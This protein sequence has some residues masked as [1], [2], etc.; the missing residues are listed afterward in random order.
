MTNSIGKGAS[1]VFIGAGVGVLMGLSVSPVVHI[2][3]TGLLTLIAAVV[4]AL[5]GIEPSDKVEQEAP[6][7]DTAQTAS[8]ESS[9]SSPAPIVSVAPDPKFAFPNIN[10]FPLFLLMVGLVAGALGGVWLRTNDILGSET[11]RRIAK[12]KATGLEE[13]EIA[14]RIFDQ[15]YPSSSPDDKKSDEKILGGAPGDLIEKWTKLG[16]DKKVAANRLFNQVY[17]VAPIPPAPKTTEVKKA[18]EDGHVTSGI[19]GLYT[20]DDDN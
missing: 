17:P 8:G 18:E 4:S 3:I 6:K 20:N 14:I 9:V 15:R 12:W 1:I 16:V 19:S 10:P 11:G 13:K 5:A 7:V 2:V